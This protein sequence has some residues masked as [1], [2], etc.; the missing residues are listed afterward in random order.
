MIG[1]I[2]QGVQDLLDADPLRLTWTERDQ[3]ADGV[4][5]PG[6]YG[7]TDRNG[8]FYTPEQ[9]ISMNNPASA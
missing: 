3:N 4:V 9:L 5:E 7:A 8:N 6:E 2:E 1:P